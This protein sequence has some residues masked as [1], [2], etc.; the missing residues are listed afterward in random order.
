MS[1][2][3]WIYAFADGKADGSGKDK[4]LLGGKGAGLA[5]MTRLGLPVPPGFTVSTQACAWFF[6]HGETWP[7]D[8][9]GQIDASLADL[10]KTTG[11]KLGDS[12]NPLLVSVRSGAAVSMPGMMDTILNLGLNDKTVEALAKG[13]GDERFAWDSYRRF[14]TMFGDVVLGIHYTRFAKAEE[15]VGAG[16]PVGELAPAQLKALAG[17]LQEVVKEFGHE[18]PQD[19]KEQLRLS[20]DAVFRSYNSHRARYYRKHQGIP[21][22]AG[23]AVN[24][25]AMVFGNMGDGSGTGVGFTRNPKTG[26]AGLFGEWLPNAQG[27]DV[28]AGI[29]TPHAVNHASARE[30]STATLEDAMPAVYA[31][32]VRLQARLEAHYRDMQDIEFTIE[33]GKLFLLQ[34][35]TGKRSAQ[36]AVQIVVDLVAEGLITR[37]EGLKRIDP[38]SLELVLR[39]VVSPD[40]KRKVIA[41]G[42]DASPGAA[43]GRVVFDSADCQAYFEQNEPTV[44]VRLET[45]PEDIQGMTVALGVLTARGGQTSHAAVV[46][47]GM[48]KP[49]VV[50]CSDIQVD[51]QRALFYAGDSVVRKGDW[52]TIDGGTGEVMLGKVEM[53]APQTDAGAMATLLGWADEV[54]RLKVRANADTGADARKARQLGARGIGLCRTE[55]MFFQPEAL[56][57][58]RRMILADDPKSRQR[59]LNDIL[60]IQRGMFKELFVEMSGLPVTI[61]LLDPPLH[62]FL[63]V[64]DQDISEVASDLGVRVEALHA[65]LTL[66]HEANPMMGHRGVR[67]GITSPE[68]YA[69][70][71][72]AIFEAAAECVKEGHTV[73]PEVMIPLVAMPSELVRT[74]ALVV[75]TAEAVIGEFGLQGRDGLA[76]TVGTMI[77]LPRAALLADQIAQHADFF[78][79]GTNDLSQMT[80]GFSRDDMGK[81]FAT[82]QREGILAE[83]PLAV[84]DIEGVGQLVEIAL[85]KG[86]TTKPKLKAGVCGE[87]GGDPHGIVFFHAVGL[88]YV[89]C[90]PYRVPVARLAAA[91]AALGAKG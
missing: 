25:Q 69:T 50:G 84:F 62:E 2:N 89:S 5:E 45:S 58:I 33:R 4:P 14:I 20:I 63:P 71:V 47:R 30:A 39:P 90:S 11:K 40:A 74:R 15:E 66:L 86:R 18:F 80:F 64:R 88:D 59:A 83:S 7:D 24:V 23:T 38:R 87:H 41:K 36:A 13:S 35:R 21:D 44:L 49:C 55:H 52:I 65:R 73:L 9:Q 10:E 67:L 70:Q 82:Y 28:V 3:R 85:Q 60:P 1:A 48:G 27:E 32:L 42:L 54:A 68:V 26:A 6:Q 17:K 19:P 43:C 51:Y 29:R 8:L 77:E 76:Y 37:E 75:E 22:D 34:T 61:R 91:H 56:R 81:F 31:E 72:R 46:A 16:K 79:F 78:S 12:E 57:A 53:L